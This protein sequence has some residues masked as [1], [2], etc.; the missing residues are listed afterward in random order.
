M[1]L[2]NLAMSSEDDWQ[3]ETVRKYGN[4]TTGY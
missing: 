1:G 4:F 3:L 2:A